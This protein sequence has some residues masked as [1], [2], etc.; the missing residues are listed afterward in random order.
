SM[1]ESSSKLLATLFA[2]SRVYTVSE[3]NEGIKE[4]LESEFF[5]LHVQGE[6]SN[7]KRHTSGHWYFTLKDAHSQ[8][9]A[10]FFRQWNR[11][12]R[13]E[14][15]NGLEVRLRG[16]LSVYEP[17][18]EYQIVVETVEPVGVGTLQL[19]FQ[20]QVKRLS[21]DGLFDE[22]R[23]RSL[24]AYP[25]CIG[26]VT[27]PVG[28]VLRDM[29]QILLRRN[30][31]INILIAPVR[32]QGNGA[33]GEIADAI[34]LLNRYAKQ[35]G[36]QLDVIIVGRGGGSMEDL[37]AFNE[38]Q[39]ARAIFS[40][41]LPVVSAVGHETDYTI[42][43]F[44]ADLRAPTPSAAAEL[45]AVEASALIARFEA[46]QEHLRRATIYDLLR[47]RQQLRNL[48]ESRGFT[49]AAQLV[50]D[51]A[52]RRRELEERA[53]SALKE[54][55]RRAVWRLLDLQRRLSAT[56][57]RAPILLHQTKLVSLTQRLERAL[58]RRVERE[59]RKLAIAA[60]KLD[61]LS[62]L[63][64]LGRGYVLVKDDSGKLVTRAA[65]L[66]SSQNLKLRFEDG[67]A[68]CQVVSV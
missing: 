18:G 49:D 24:P 8:L 40:S 53:A 11:L 39:V 27:S 64:V 35:R 45:V 12:L 63:S 54:N 50:I 37:W 25:R 38:E 43:D 7:Y 56:D 68:A 42:A 58:Q 26:I 67:E 44:V 4:V 3:L 16:R 10:V 30:P 15:E 46:L 66:S 28:A 59:A 5:T 2:E 48:T 19:A 29:L 1:H 55:F 57:F 52:V 47:R 60:S 23:K 14:P 33:A 6:I 32:V 20:Q 36:N 41:E 31:A 13:F 51:F 17:R 34:R 61:T 9:R 65:Q 21:A 22:A 62:P